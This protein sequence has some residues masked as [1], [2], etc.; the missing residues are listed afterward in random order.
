MQIS[1][2]NF[3]AFARTMAAVLEDIDQRQAARRAN[4]GGPRLANP[5]LTAPLPAKSSLPRSRR[6]RDLQTGDCHV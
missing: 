5:D 3:A 2:E 1:D 6:D 4:Q